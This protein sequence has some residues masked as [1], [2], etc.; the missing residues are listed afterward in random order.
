MRHEYAGRA[1]TTPARNCIRKQYITTKCYSAKF[2]DKY[3]QL[4]MQNALRVLRGI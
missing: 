1:K 3:F 4:I 2:A